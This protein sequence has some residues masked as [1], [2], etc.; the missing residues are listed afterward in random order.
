M[1]RDEYLLNAGSHVTCDS[2]CSDAYMLQVIV[3]KQC[4]QACF[5]SRA[6]RGVAQ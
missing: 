3:D 1:I 5:E 6:L 2:G 4:L